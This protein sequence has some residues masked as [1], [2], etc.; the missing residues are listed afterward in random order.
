MMAISDSPAHNFDFK[1]WVTSGEPAKTESDREY[2][3][4]YPT[5]ADCLPEPDN[6]DYEVE[7]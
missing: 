4:D 1:R 7:S 2:P 6:T 5:E 3:D